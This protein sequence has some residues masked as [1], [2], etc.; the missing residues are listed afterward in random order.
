[1][2]RTPAAKAPDVRAADA[3]VL[4]RSASS[5]PLA[6][7]A[8]GAA[9]GSLWL[10]DPAR[11]FEFTQFIAYPPLVPLLA[12]VLVIAL[13]EWVFP[14]LGTRSAGALSRSALRPLSLGRVGV[15]LC[16]LAATL[17]LLAIAYW[18]FPEYR[19]AFYRPYWQFLQML[20]PL[21]IAVPFYFAW[22]DTRLQDPEDEYLSFGYLVLGQWGRVRW[23]LVRHHLLSWGVKGFFLPLMSAYLSEETHA[24]FAVWN[25]MTQGHWLAYDLFYHLSYGADLLFCVVGYSASM[26]LFDSQINSVEP[27]VAGWLVALACYQPF[28]SVIARNYLQYEDNIY[29]DTWLAP[30]PLARGVWGFLIVILLC[31]YAL[32]T[33]SFGLRFSNL[34]HRGII[35]SGPYRYSK[36]PAYVAKNLS[37]WLI[38]VPFISEMGLAEA[39]RNC[40]LLGLMNLLYFARARTEE[41]HLSH[42]ANYVAY[43][44]WMNEHGLLRSLSRQLPFLRYRAPAP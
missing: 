17:S 23:P 32:C 31:T 42:D 21:A 37:W 28:I 2:T 24:I 29:W 3:P 41:R 35:T 38:S 30:W 18:L 19:S 1:M 4:P 13:G 12:V 15:R 44:L 5:F 43:A 25:S 39:L 11:H 7:V 20:A 6:L 27:T 33:V 16:A 14:R 26:R 40:C 36:H 9:L 34:T 22:S 10:I 8:L